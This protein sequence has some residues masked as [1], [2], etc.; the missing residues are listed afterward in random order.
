LCASGKSTAARSGSVGTALLGGEW[1]LVDHTST[2]VTSADFLGE[3]ILIYFGFTHCPDICPEEL[4]KIVAVVDK[5]DENKKVNNLRPVFITVD[6]HRD[7]PEA[8]GKYCKDYSPKLVALTGS[9][10]Q[11]SKA[12]RAYRVY[13]SEGPKDEDEDYIVDHTIIT[14]LVNP[15]GKFQ[16]YYGQTKTVDQMVTSITN[17]MKCY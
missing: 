3:W 9:N 11:I 5:I 4:E 10:E 8:V 13:F 7:T 1:E 12:T 2:K 15:E 16:D 17:H 6:P 14:Y